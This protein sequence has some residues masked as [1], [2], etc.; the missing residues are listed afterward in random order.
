MHGNDIVLHSLDSTGK[1]LLEG[2][3]LTKRFKFLKDPARSYT[4]L[5]AVHEIFYEKLLE[6][7]QEDYKCQVEFVELFNLWR[8]TKDNALKL[9]SV[10]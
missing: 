10:S 5:Y 6:I 8:S 9:S 4:F 1:N 2:F 3:R 7:V